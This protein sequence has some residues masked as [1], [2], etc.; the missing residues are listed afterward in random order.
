VLSPLAEV[1]FEPRSVDAFEDAVEGSLAGAAG[2]G[3]AQP[4]APGG[5]VHRPL[6]DGALGAGAAQHGDAGQQRHRR[7]AM[8][9]VARLPEVG[10]LGEVVGQGRDLST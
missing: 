10:D 5:M 9:Q 8:A 4:S 3:Q 2:M 6:S 1:R 7:Q